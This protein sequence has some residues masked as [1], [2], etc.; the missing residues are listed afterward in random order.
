MR[1][2][3]ALCLIISATLIAGRASFTGQLFYGGRKVVHVP[4]NEYLEVD[5][6]TKYTLRLF[7]WPVYQCE[8]TP[9][10]LEVRRLDE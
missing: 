7:G 2:I 1:T 5:L 9:E 8:L 3:L 4:E 6:R 10:I